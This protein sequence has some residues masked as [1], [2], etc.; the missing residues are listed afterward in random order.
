[1]RFKTSI[2]AL[3][4]AALIAWC[5][6]VSIG[7]PAI[8]N[9]STVLGDNASITISGTGFGTHALD[10]EFLGG[11]TG[12]IES[13]SAGTKL[14]TRSGWSYPLNFTNDEGQPVVSTADKRSGSKSL[15]GHVEGAVYSSNA[16]FS[17][18]RFDTLYARF[19]FKPAN[20]EWTDGTTAAYKF[21]RVAPPD[22]TGYTISV[23]N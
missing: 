18:A 14:N 22:T 5:T 19:W 6:G 9:V 1:M 21:W 7:A 10:I 3:C 17:H 20:F 11:S 15:Y 2:I 23:M 8:T 16:M 12:W 4:A 13:Q